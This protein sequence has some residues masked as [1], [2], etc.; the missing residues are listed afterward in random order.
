MF[1]VRFFVEIDVLTKGLFSAAGSEHD[2]LAAFDGLRT[3]ILDVAKRVYSSKRKNS[4][5]LKLAD[6]R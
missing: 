5:I 2:Y 4:I 6:F 3:K 1:E